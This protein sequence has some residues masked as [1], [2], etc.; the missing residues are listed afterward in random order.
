MY[1]FDGFCVFSSLSLL[2]SSFCSFAL[3]AR[4]ILFEIRFPFVVLLLL[5][6]LLLAVRLSIKHS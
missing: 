1:T 5:L 6:L 2:L 3:C 4:L